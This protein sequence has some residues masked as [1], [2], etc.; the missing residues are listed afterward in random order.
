ME[1]NL[2]KKL[3]PSLGTI[4]DVAKESFA[5]K[6][7]EEKERSQFKNI[8]AS[9]EYRKSYKGAAQALENLHSN[10]NDWLQKKS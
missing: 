10:P 9:P 3:F 8:E 6:Q 1:N 4:K 2:P 5:Q 7:K